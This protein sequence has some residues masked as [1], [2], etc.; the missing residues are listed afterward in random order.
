MVHLPV[1]LVNLPTSMVGCSSY[2]STFNWHS[3]PSMDNQN[4]LVCK[5][6]IRSQT[7]SFFFF[8]NKGL[9]CP[10]WS[11]VILSVAEDC[12]LWT[13]SVWLEKRYY[14]GFRGQRSLS[15]APFTN[16]SFFQVH[17]W[18]SNAVGEQENGAISGWRGGHQGSLHL[19]TSLVVMGC[20]HWEMEM[21]VAIQQNQTCREQ[22][23]LWSLY[24]TVVL[25]QLAH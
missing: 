8:L 22:S 2:S 19:Q 3:T 23:T 4:S 7:I 5:Q 20:L 21:V 10:S 17:H 25:V 1:Q 11:Q 14:T 12:C 15:A 9:N 24:C 18:S 6:S 13:V 16:T